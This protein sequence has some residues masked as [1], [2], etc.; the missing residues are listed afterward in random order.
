MRR[1]RPLACAL[2][3]GVAPWMAGGGAVPAVVTDHVGTCLRCQAEL[4]RHRRAQRQLRSLRNE[5]LTP[6]PG[7]VTATLEAL[8]ALADLDHSRAWGAPSVVA[9]AA[10]AAGAAAGVA[11]VWVWRRRQAV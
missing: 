5:A 7:A 4:V 6:P 8:D 1:E 11:G 9:T 10:T 3:A 2:A